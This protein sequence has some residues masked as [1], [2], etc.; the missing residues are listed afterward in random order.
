MLKN[1]KFVIHE[2]NYTLSDN[3]YPDNYLVKNKTGISVYENGKY[4]ILF[5]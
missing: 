4:S 1:G 3:T 5:L 2:C